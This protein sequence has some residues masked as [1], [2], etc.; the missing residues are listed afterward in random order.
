M[1]LVSNTPCASNRATPTRR[2]PL[3]DLNTPPIKIAP[4]GCCVTAY[5]ELSVPVPGSKAVSTDPFGFKR[6]TPPRT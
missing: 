1:K 5:T 6:A 2:V 3:K 4:S